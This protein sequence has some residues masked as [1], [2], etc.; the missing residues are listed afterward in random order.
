MKRIAL[1][2]P[3]DAVRS[4]LMRRVRRRGTK[5]EQQVAEVLRG[6]GIFYR[7]NVLSLPGSPDFANKAHKWAVFV[8]GCFWHHHHG[9]SRATIPTRNRVFWTAKFSANRLRDA[10]KSEALVSMGF[11]VVVIWECEA[12]KPLVTRRRLR[13]LRT[14]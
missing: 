3:T 4:D 8:N 7:R 9:C 5:A 1:L 6:L 12:M 14:R 13:G 2:P 10:I 11:K